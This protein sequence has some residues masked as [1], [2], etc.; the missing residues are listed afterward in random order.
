MDS[1]LGVSD[2]TKFCTNSFRKILHGSTKELI[3][4]SGWPDFVDESSS[5]LDSPA[6]CTC[7]CNNTKRI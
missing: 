2:G 6:F 5:K 1:V 7:R 4:G 3:N